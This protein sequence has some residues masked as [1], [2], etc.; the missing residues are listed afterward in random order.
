MSIITNTLAAATFIT[1][2]AIITGMIGLFREADE[3]PRFVHDL[4]SMKNS[5]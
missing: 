2:T 4:Q 3:N 1:G 5:Q